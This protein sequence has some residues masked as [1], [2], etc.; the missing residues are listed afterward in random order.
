MDVEALNK[1]YNNLSP[2]KRI[3]ELYNDFDKILFTSSFGTTSVLLL[4]MFS[5]VKPE[6]DVFFLDTTY[7]FSETIEY[8]NLLT[9]KL[10]L[11][12]K[13]VLPE[14]WKNKFTSEDKTWKK[15]PDLCCSI[16]KVEPLDKV[17][18]NYRVW[19]SG[20]MAW[21]TPHR[22]G[23][24]IFEKR[25]EIIKFHPLIDMKLLEM[26]NYFLEYNLPEHP[27]MKQGY[28]SIGCVHCTAK[29]AG[30]QGRWINKSKVECGLH[31]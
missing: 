6:Q 26:K 29:G 18:K 24:S 20:L 23:L 8:K 31:L 5:K 14:E 25:E 19:V 7:H 10:N 9:K 13:S 3:E 15:D 28:N 1:K 12:V 22:T 21:Q 30:R 17:K 11:K 4:H 16:N 2:A 27:L